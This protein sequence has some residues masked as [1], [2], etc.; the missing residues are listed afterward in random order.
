MSE[1]IYS[2]SVQTIDQ[3]TVKLDT[4]QGKVLLIVNTASKCGFTLQYEELQQ[5]QTKYGADNFTVLAFPCNQFGNQEPQNNVEIGEFCQLNYQV[6][7]PVFAKIAVNG[8]EAEPLFTYLKSQ[9]AGLLGIKKIKW[10]F[11]KFL[12]DKNGT[13]VQRYAPITAPS[14]LTLDIEKYLAD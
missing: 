4:Y 11:T 13:V 5:L 3:Q 10:N 14:K 8:N 7:F 2:F 9:Q 6:S 12:I 1:K